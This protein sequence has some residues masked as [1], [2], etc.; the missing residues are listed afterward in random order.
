MTRNAAKVSVSLWINAHTHMKI[1]TQR[2]RNNDPKRCQST[3]EPLNQRTL[4][5]KILT[6]RDRN[7][8]TK[9]CQSTRGPL[10]QRTL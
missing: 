4:S 6:R 1:L 2:D 8:D 5:K 7:N 9:R 3:R 10:D